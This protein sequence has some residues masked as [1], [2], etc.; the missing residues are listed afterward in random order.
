MRVSRLNE[1]VQEFIFTVNIIFGIP[2]GAE[3]FTTLQNVQTG[4]HQAPHSTA[5]RASSRGKAAGK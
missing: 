2:T 5:T 4:V 3:S 1:R